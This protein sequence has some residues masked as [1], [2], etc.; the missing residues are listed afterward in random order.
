MKYL[1]VLGTSVC[2]QSMWTKIVLMQ[3]EEEEE[4]EEEEEKEEEQQQQNARKY[5][6]S[7]PSSIKEQ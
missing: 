2:H 6:L 4:E 3:T 1:F 7:F 5:Q